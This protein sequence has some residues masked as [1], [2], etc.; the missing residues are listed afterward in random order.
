MSSQMRGVVIG[1]GVVLL[2]SCVG[3]DGSSV[4]ELTEA[5][6]TSGARCAA[7][8]DCAGVANSTV[9]CNNQ[10]CNYTCNSGFKVCG[11]RCIPNASC[12]TSSECM[13]GPPNTVG[14]CSATANTCSYACAFP[15][16]CRDGTVVCSTWA[17]ES[18]TLEGWSFGLGNLEPNPTAVVTS[19]RAAVGSSSLF[20]PVS[21]IAWVQV[22][23]CP[24]VGANMAQKFIHAQVYFDTGGVAFN[25]TMQDLNQVFVRL[26]TDP[27][28]PPFSAQTYAV[29][30]YL[31]PN[32]LNASPLFIP[33][34]WWNL[35]GV[36][37]SDQVGT[38]AAVIQ[39]GIQ[40]TGAPA[41][42]TQGK[43]F[44]DDV[45]IF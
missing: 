10:R 36:I 35:N 21:T 3:A 8:R 5:P 43:L 12:C 22:P 20:V 29:H 45:R 15:L 6:F 40:L 38:H 30:T 39:I 18:R 37:P 42:Y 4:V 27:N 16:T 44:V 13:S 32:P 31:D 34:Q 11:Q 1:L 17:F 41:N 7:R 14:T 9:S 28:I 24:G 23:V 19:A 33:N 2:W 25:N 26:T